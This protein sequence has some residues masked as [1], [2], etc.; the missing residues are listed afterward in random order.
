MQKQLEEPNVLR[1]DDLKTFVTATGPCVSLYFADHDPGEKTRQDEVRLRNALEG[2]ESRLRELGFDKGAIAELLD[3]VRAI[4][5][6]MGP[7]HM[8]G[9]AF[10][11][12]RSPDVFRVFRPMDKVDEISVVAEHFYILPI[13]GMLDADRHWYVLALSQKNVRLLKCTAHSSE[14]VSLPPGTPTALDEWLNTRLPNESP[15]QRGPAE[16]TPKEPGATL[17]TFTSQT[18]RDRKDEFLQNFFREVDKGVMEFLRGESAPLVLAG[19]EQ[20]VGFYKRISG[21]LHLT[22]GAVHGSPEG[23][24]GGEIHSRALPIVQEHLHL[25][26][27]KALESLDRASNDLRAVGPAH[28][29]KAA[30]EGRVA[31][32]FVAKTGAMWGSFNTDNMEI[33]VHP[34]R[35]LNSEDLIN[36]AV[37]EA[38]AH[39]SDVWPLPPE[40]IPGNAQVLAVLRY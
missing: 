2:A 17:G 40:Q 33:Q 25:P 9:N 3:P 23:L 34:E 20:Q 21:Y 29:V 38:I 16:E 4:A 10:A 27:K 7:W 26:M 19:V 32:L 14:E 36:L 6:E 1:R 13:L 11:I 24:K 18:D 28:C 8:E 37:V 15:D 5:D 22:D 39:G 31:H 30:Y 35:Q 12:F